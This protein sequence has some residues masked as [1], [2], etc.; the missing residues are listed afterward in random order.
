MCKGKDE[1][2]SILIIIHGILKN[3]KFLLGN[4]AY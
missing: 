3:E 1:A 4:F 2:V